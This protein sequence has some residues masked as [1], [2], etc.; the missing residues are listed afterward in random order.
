[1][2]FEDS[3]GEVWKARLADQL[4]P[5]ALCKGR[6][7]G[8][9]W[10]WLSQRCINLRCPNVAES[11]IIT[12]RGREIIARLQLSLTPS[13]LVIHLIVAMPDALAPA[14]TKEER[15][16]CLHKVHDLLSAICIVH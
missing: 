16:P 8:Q 15:A 4:H 3:A 10:F 12:Q 9:A 2:I 5:A 11:N 7:W 6:W 1:M 14:G 13:L